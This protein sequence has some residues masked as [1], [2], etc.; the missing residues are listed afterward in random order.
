MNIVRL[1]V[2]ILQNCRF[3]HRSFITLHFLRNCTVGSVCPDGKILYF[4]DMYD[5]PSKIPP[6]VGFK[7]GDEFPY[8][9]L[10]VHYAREMEMRSVVRARVELT[11]TKEKYLNIKN[12]CKAIILGR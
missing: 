9:V 6:K 5:L 11:I 7:V 3:F 12:K 4:W 10:Q 2:L 1:T 8:V